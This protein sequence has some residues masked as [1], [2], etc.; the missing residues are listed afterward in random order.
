MENALLPAILMGGLSLACIIVVLAGFRKAL[1][2]TNWDNRTRNRSFNLAVALMIGWVTALEILST[3][4]FFSNF[5]TLPPRILLVPVT[6]FFIA[7]LVAFSKGFTT[8]AKTTPAHWLVYFQAFRILVEIL[9]WIAF[10]KGLLPEQMSFEGYNMDVLTG[11][12][13]LPVGWALAKRKSWSRVTAIIFNIIGL[14][15]LF[16]IITIAVLSMPT[17]FRQ[18]MNEPSNSIVAEFPFIYLPGVL[19]VLAF[20]FHVLS[21]R[22][23]L[24]RKQSTS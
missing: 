4:G 9:L 19:V 21:L 12:L 23:L 3:N 17:P 24:M 2:L 20:G 18:F 16:N 14:L 1:R 11:I 6:G 5:S 8:L 22:Q 15:L 10:K 13:A 7:L